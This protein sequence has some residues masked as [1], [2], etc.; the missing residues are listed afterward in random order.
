MEFSEIIY[1]KGDRVATITFNRP[2]SLNAFTPTLGLELKTAM[3]DADGDNSI[4][5]IVVTGAGRAFCSGFDVKVGAAANKALRSGEQR[6][7]SEIHDNWHYMLAMGTPIIGA[8]K[9]PCVFMG[10]T[11]T[12]FFDFRILGE[13]ARY[14]LGFS[15]KGLAL[16]QGAAW[17]LPRLVGIP[18]ALDLAITGRYIAPQEALQI[19]LANRVVPDAQL[20]TVAH[21]FARDL[22]STT[23][24]TAVA[25]AKRAVYKHLSTDFDAAYKASCEEAMKQNQTEDFREARR[26]MAE[27]RPPRF[28]GR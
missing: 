11:M 3:Q 5:A 23:A 24:P 28:P 25:Q 22:A 20:L 1:E 10:F 14:G 12:L 27:K 17:I 2:D 9:G 15:Q 16:E 6:A 7:Y 4:G 18:R 19:G 13:S 26:A 8:I 21:E